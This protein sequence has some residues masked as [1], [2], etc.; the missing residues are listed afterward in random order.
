MKHILLALL[1]NLLWL[2]SSGA[3]VIVSDTF[4]RANTSGTM[5]DASGK[6]WR[7]ATAN[8]EIS[9]NKVQCKVTQRCDAVGALASNI[10][11]SQ[12][13]AVVSA[14][15]LDGNAVTTFILCRNQGNRSDYGVQY[16]GVA[17]VI[18]RRINGA[19]ATL[20]T[21]ASIN[22][23]ASSSVQI[24]C[25]D[26]EINGYEDGVL[27]VGPATDSQWSAGVPAFYNAAFTNTGQQMFD[28]FAACD[29]VAECSNFSITGAASSAPG[30]PSGKSLLG[31]GN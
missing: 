4:T 31:V 9:D 5:E 19:E 29:A 15:M 24:S 3:A 28:N 27:V 20:A 30:G 17:Y 7:D 10:T 6:G 21:G 8:A 23:L 12:A 2:G 1:L 11:T 14:K 16:N 22:R 26:T 25:V 18:I 13:N